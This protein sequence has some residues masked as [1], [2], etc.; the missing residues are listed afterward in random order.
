MTG[1]TADLEFA[2]T[3]GIALTDALDLVDPPAPADSDAMVV[4]TVRVPRAI[5][6]AIADAADA[7]GV[8]PSA[9]IRGAIEA[10]LAGRER[11]GLVNVDD[12][13]RA[14]EALPRAVV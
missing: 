14:I 12:V 11:S 1:E 9:W 13:L 5:D 10:S 6:R 2:S 8:S 7:A 4:K 3:D